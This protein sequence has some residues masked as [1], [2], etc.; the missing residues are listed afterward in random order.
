MLCRRI[1]KKG[2]RWKWVL[3]LKYPKKR[4][5]LE[6]GICDTRDIALAELRAAG[7]RFKD[8][9][10]PREK[11][12]KQSRYTYIVLYDGHQAI[13]NNAVSAVDFMEVVESESLDCELVM[14]Q[15][16]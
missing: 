5:R 13:F 3:Y 7:K 16:G 4:Y 9:D 11:P 15:K 6:A 10:K 2:E 1:F 12:M 14:I 8:V